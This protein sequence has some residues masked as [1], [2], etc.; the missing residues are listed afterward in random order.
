MNVALGMPP[1]RN[2]TIVLRSLELIYLVKTT[3]NY[4]VCKMSV[5]TNKT[6]EVVQ[7]KRTRHMDIA[8][9]GIYLKSTA[10]QVTRTIN[11]K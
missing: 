9:K 2:I 4:F 7:Y 11:L 10:G 1:T 5:S 6:F 8:E 3:E